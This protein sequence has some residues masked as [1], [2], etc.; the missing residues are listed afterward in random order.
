[1]SAKLGIG[2]L[3]GFLD[4]QFPYFWTMYFYMLLVVIWL[5][6]SSKTLL[7]ITKDGLNSQKLMLVYIFW[8]THWCNI[9]YKMAECNKCDNDNIY[10][11]NNFYIY[12]NDS[13]DEFWPF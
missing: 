10:C 8:D 13:K 1:M 6:V 12:D 3:A 11:V 2:K 7:L 9:C 5:F 4:T